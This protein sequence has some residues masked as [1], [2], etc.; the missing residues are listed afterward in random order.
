LSSTETLS[1]NSC[2]RF[3]GGSVATLRPARML[4]AVPSLGLYDPVEAG[5]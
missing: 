3:A 1:A 5:R 2:A 4:I